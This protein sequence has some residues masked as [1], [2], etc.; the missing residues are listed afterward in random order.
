MNQIQIV[1][2]LQLRICICLIIWW[3]DTN[4]THVAFKINFEK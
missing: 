4:L 3:V 1:K 2:E